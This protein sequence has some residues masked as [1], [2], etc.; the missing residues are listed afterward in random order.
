MAEAGER[1]G[2]SPY[3]DRLLEGLEGEVVEVGAGSG[4]N[5]LHY[6]DSVT[7]VVA[8]EPEPYLRARAASAARA[9]GVPIEVVEGSAE[10]IPLPP[11]SV[12]AAVVSLVLCSVA[13][14]AE[15]LAEIARV[16]RPAGELRYFEHVRAATASLA[17]LQDALDVVWPKL[18]AG[19]HPNRDTE[20]AI[21]RAGFE[22]TG[23]AHSALDAPLI[24]KPVSFVVVGRAVWPGG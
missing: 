8:V 11:A 23:S 17:R 5:F 15:S 21:T 1:K 16:L 3:R 19:C 14:Q 18:G 6:P 22:V 24:A 2:T 10:H 12:D 20:A 13:D 4:T 7:K 9:A